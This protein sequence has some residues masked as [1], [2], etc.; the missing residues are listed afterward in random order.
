[1]ENKE[2]YDPARIR[3]AMAGLVFPVNI[4]D[5]SVRIVTYCADAFERLD[6]I[7]YGEFRSKIRCIW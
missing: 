2:V 1:M 3:E 4:I 6:L 7:G 5:A